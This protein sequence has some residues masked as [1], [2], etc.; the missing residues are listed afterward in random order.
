MADKVGNSHISRRKFLAW[1]GVLAATAGAAP[2]LSACGTSAVPAAAPTAA[3]AAPKPAAPTQS[4]A[5]AGVIELKLSH[6]QPPTTSIGKMWQGWAD[7]VNQKAAGRMRVTVYPS[8]TLLP[9]ADAYQGVIKGTADMA[10]TP[11]AFLTGQF[12]LCEA[13]ELP[14]MGIRDAMHGSRVATAWFR[15]N[16][17]VQKEWSEVKVLALFAV[18]AA[19]PVAIKKKITKPEDVRGLKMAL[20]GAIGPANYLKNL[21]ASPVAMPLPDMYE[22]LNKGIV[23]SYLQAWSAINNVKLYELGGYAVDLGIQNGLCALSMNK[24]KFESLP[25]DLQKILEDPGVK[26]SPAEYIALSFEEPVVAEAKTAFT[27][28]GGQIYTPTEEERKNWLSY[29]K[30]VWDSWIEQMKGK[31]FDPAKEFAALQDLIVKTK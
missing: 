12:P 15:A 28:A 8:Q 4:P 21:G 30:P 26:P 20:A 5:Q 2:L 17:V 27:K 14:A 23:D 13:F 3:S 31:G 9:V 11:I 19:I 18:S 1:G 22:A 29:G 24:Q 16:P 25:P 6:Q 10:W 7:A